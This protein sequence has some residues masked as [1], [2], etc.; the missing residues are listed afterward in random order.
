MSSDQDRNGA[1]QPARPRPQTP[2]IHAIL[3]DLDKKPGSGFPW[4]FLFFLV[5][6]G[7]VGYVGYQYV[8]DDLTIVASK[9]SYQT[10]EVARGPLA[11]SIT[12]TGSI[13]PTEK[14]DIS[15]E[16]SGTVKKVL[17]DYNSHVSA[18]DP[19][20]ELDTDELK[21]DILS[22]KA[23]LAAAKSDV[24]AAQSTLESAK[25]T[26]DRTQTLVDRDVAPRQDLQDAQFAY[27]AAIAGKDSADAQ[28]AVAE[29]ELELAELK[30]SKATIRS[31]ID[32]VVLKRNVDVGQTV[33][34]SLEAPT[35][36]VIAG[37]LKKMELRVDIDEADVGQVA[38]GQKATFTVEAYPGQRFPAEIASIR[39]AS[40]LASDVVTYKA[41]LSVANDDLTLRQGMT[42]T[43]DIFVDENDD[44]LLVPNAALRYAPPGA[45]QTPPEN[46]DGANHRRVYLLR[47]DEARP[48]DIVVGA[49]NGQ[50]SEVLE[51][52]LRAGDTLITGAE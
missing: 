10:V 20:L 46:S 3:G 13:E 38:I 28:V 5:V 11:V 18:G 37:D 21:A 33:A 50:F 44:A 30:L 7:A 32:G 24:A 25:V 42:A 8:R 43:A 9:P 49:S 6:L 48:V 35:L 29:A 41:V 34:A 1:E 14:V 22:V 27:N 36:F 19:L 15:S 12:A 26:M 40:E 45:D 31:P 16:L 39:Y 17:V 4:R 47:N 23:K 2:D 52:D 51:G